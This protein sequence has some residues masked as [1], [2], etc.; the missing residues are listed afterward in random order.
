MVE[1]WVV[2]DEKIIM[3]ESKRKRSTIIIQKINNKMGTQA[4]MPVPACFLKSFWSLPPKST[5]KLTIGMGVLKLCTLHVTYILS[6]VMKTTTSIAIHNN[7]YIW[8][9]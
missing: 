6:L 9:L 1:I 3:K 4:M 8:V 7:D 2:Q 5:H